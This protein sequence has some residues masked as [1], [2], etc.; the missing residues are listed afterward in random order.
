MIKNF[1]DI[2]A[3]VFLGF[4]LVWL[5]ALSLMIWLLDISVIEALGLGTA[6]GAL[7]TIMALI[8]QF[9]FRRATAAEEK[10]PEQ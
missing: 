5:I 9:Y 3:L 4:I 6:T 2:L 7:L 1:R 10:P 8:F